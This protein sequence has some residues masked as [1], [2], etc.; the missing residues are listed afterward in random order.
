MTSR[1]EKKHTLVSL[2]LNELAA[3]FDALV[4]VPGRA[5]SYEHLLQIRAGKERKARYQALQYLQRKKLIE[6]RKT[7]AGLEVALTASGH[8]KAIRDQLEA[9]TE[10]LPK[11]A[12]C[13]VIFDIP[14]KARQARDNFRNLLK[15]CRFRM[16]QF[17]VWESDRNY[18][19][20]LKLFIREAKI[21][22]WVTILE[23]HRK[24]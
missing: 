4:S 21:G 24:S 8:A 15:R 6:I 12:T 7:A 13:I 2:I 22:K 9:N 17:S 14:E 10:K 16:I 19:H 3:D 5:K 1:G 23:A 18:F 20:L 11:G